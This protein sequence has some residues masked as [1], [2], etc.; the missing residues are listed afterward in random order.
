M[1]KLFE[2][3]KLCVASQRYLISEHAVELLDERRILEW[4]VVDGIQ[5]GKLISERERDT[6][7]PTVE[8]LQILADGT[9]VKAVWAWLKTIDVAKLVTVHFMDN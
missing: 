8:V 7:N 2:R 1:G 4:Q 9:D 3:I 6:P 5:A